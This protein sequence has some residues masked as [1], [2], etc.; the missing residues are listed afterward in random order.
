MNSQLWID[1][2]LRNRDHRPE[3][4]W[5]QHF[6]EDART[7]ALLSDSLAQFQL[8]ES[9]EGTVLLAAARRVCADE[10][11]YAEALGLFIREEQEHA[12]LLARLIERFGGRRLQRHWTQSL[13]RVLRRSF[14]LL[15]EIQ[16]LIIAE[17]VGT[18]YYRALQVRVRDVVLE[19]VCALVLRD[20]QAHVAFHAERFASW[21]Q[22]WLPLERAAW[23]A[24]FQLAF[25]AAASIAWHAHGRALGATGVRKREFFSAARRECIAFLAAAEPP[26]PARPEPMLAQ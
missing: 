22:R 26:L 6:P 23:A 1:Y 3:P 18:A 25:F 16:V 17:L 20:E 7:A 10:P 12:R 11:A 24:Q 21:Q 4:D 19:Q 2:F 5:T 13:F 14:G 15:G 8:G 9:G